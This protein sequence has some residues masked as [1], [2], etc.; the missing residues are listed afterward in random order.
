MPAR[1]LLC[2]GIII[3]LSALTA[4]SVL[5]AETDAGGP[6]KS[7][8]ANAPASQ[9]LPAQFQATVYEVKATADRVGALDGKTLATKA[10]TAEGLL[11]VLTNS[12]P[13]RILYRVDQPVNV[14][15]EKILVGSSEPVITAT[16]ISASGQP[17]NTVTHQNVGVHVRLSAEAP[18]GE[19]KGRN[20]G[21]KMSMG[22]S[23]LVPS[24]IELAPGVPATTTRS[25]SIEHE[26]TLE[27][28]QPL[29]V[30]TVYS[31]ATQTQAIPTAY[32]IRYLFR[33]PVGK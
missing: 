3:L 32:V 8:P 30:V 18:S 7:G 24:G 23:V 22:L 20:P 29:V 33:R 13:A 14:L 28:D 6:G 5:G 4:G 17:V 21:V 15:S 12:G 10:A 1:I 27:F 2:S 9:I 11:S 26:E 16:R 19:A 31:E 25:M